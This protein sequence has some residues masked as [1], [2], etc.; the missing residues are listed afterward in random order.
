MESRSQSLF[1]PIFELEDRSE[2]RLL[3]DPARVRRP[4]SEEEG[5]GSFVI[6]AEKVEEGR[7]YSIF[8][9][10]R[11]MMGG[12]SFFGTGKSKNPPSSKNPIFEEPPIFEETP[13]FEEF[14]SIF[15]LRNRRSQNPHFRSSEPE[16]GR[17]P[18]LRSSVSKIEETSLFDF[19]PRK[20]I[21]RSDERRRGVQ[22]P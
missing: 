17:T 13:V 10:R 15:D 20:M 5:G 6:P 3:R 1:G 14:P 22:L 21:R 11:S 7:S 18:L 8:R 4:G 2:I 19:R 16:D 9:V 12:Y